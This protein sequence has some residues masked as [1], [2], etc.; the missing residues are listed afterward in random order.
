MKKAILFSQQKKPVGKRGFTLIELLI[1]IIL[2]GIL[3]S[4]A[5]ASLHGYTKRQTL[6]Q[7][8][9]DMETN[10]RATRNRSISG[11]DGLLWGV[12]LTAGAVSYEIFSTN[13]TFAYSFG[14][15]EMSEELPSQVTVSSVSPNDGGVVNVVFNRLNG[16]VRVCDNGG[17][18]LS[19]PSL[20]IHLRHAGV[21]GDHRVWVESGGKIYESQ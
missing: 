12:H 9:K 17:S 6:S 16:E 4:I 1:V 8:A 14:Q 19:S 18:P 11:L 7:A 15:I 20:E 5:I 21:S 13:D 2:I 3:T 10:L